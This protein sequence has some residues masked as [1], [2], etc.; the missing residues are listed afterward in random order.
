MS[1]YVNGIE[2]TELN[3]I[4]DELMRYVINEDSID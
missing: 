4:T 2:L 3:H 1:A